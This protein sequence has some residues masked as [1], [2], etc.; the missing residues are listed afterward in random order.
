MIRHL[1]LFLCLIIGYACTPRKVYLSTSFREPATDGLRFI[2]SY[3]GYHWDSVPGVWLVPEVGTQRLM[4]DPSI[5]QAPDGTFHLVWTSSWRDDYGIGYASSQD[6]IHWTPQRHIELMRDYDTLTRNVWAPELF[7]EPTTAE[8][9]IVWASAIPGRF[10]DTQRQYYTVTRDFE[11]FTS[12]RL[13]YDPGYNSI[14]GAV[15]RRGDGDY[16]LAVKDN[17]KPGYSHIH[18]SFGTTPVGPWHDDSAPFT[19]EWSEGPTWV[20]V[21]DDYLIYFDLYK[22]YR[23]GAVRTSDFETFVDITDSI[24]VPPRHKHG[25]IIEVDEHY[26]RRLLSAAGNSKN[27]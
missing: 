22:Q 15:L 20:R 12:P 4:R 11:T 3:D 17:R 1:L 7:Y 21:G 13:F 6:L 25:T 19:P 10:D 2:Y 23:Y 24:S 26:L 16:V 9:D 18:V 14:D 8:Y 5:I 27:L